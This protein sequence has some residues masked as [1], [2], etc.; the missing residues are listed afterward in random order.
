MR[1]QPLAEVFG[2]PPDYLSEQAEH[3]REFK[4]CPY[5]NKG[6]KCTKDKASNP[7]GVCCIFQGEQAVITCPVR[8]RQDWLIAKKA[9]EFFFEEE[10]SW[11]PL[12]EVRL[13]DRSGKSAGNIDVVLV[14]YD[15]Q[16]NVIDFG[17]LEV[18]AVYISGNVRQPFE[19]YMEDR[20]SRKDMDWSKR[21]HYY[22]RPDFL[23][24]RK[25]LIPQLL[26]KGGILHAW[27]KKQA[28]ALQRVFF[29]TLPDLPGVSAA[30]A[31][32]AWFLYD[33]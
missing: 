3:Y 11:T 12:T 27:G 15:D 23:S 14:A 7:L 20:A 16:D 1:H 21:A 18:Q 33:L 26:Y 4:H 28:V 8:F 22:P 2:F 19:Y 9:A 29:D 25:R 30:D 6:L 13:K 5:N 32:I 17:S 24:S 10:V 31:E